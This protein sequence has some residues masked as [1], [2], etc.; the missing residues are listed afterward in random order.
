MDFD[1][2]QNYQSF[3]PPPASDFMESDLGVP[4]AEAT[5]PLRATRWVVF[6]GDVL[7]PA[8]KRRFAGMEMGGENLGQD[9]KCL[10]PSKGLLRRCQLTPMVVGYDFLNEDILGDDKSRAVSFQHFDPATN[11]T[12]VRYAYECLP[13]HEIEGLLRSQ[14]GGD[15]MG[16]REVEVLQNIDP[17]KPIKDGQGRTV[18]YSESLAHSIQREIFP[19]WDAYLLGENATGGKAFFRTS[20]KLGDYLRAR[21]AELFGDALDVIDVLIESNE[22]FI[23]WG[24]AYLSRMSRLVKAAPTPGGDTYSWSPLALQLFDML[25]LNKEEF[26]MRKIE[27]VK[28]EPE[29]SREEFSEMRQ[30]W[31]EVMPVIGHLARIAVANSA[32]TATGTAEPDY[33]AQV[34][35][36]FNGQ[37]NPCKARV[38]KEIDGA[39]YCSSHPRVEADADN[40]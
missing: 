2:Q 37:G 23:R 13:G 12:S 20:V 7:D 26:L 36:D 8:F 16:I 29:V 18:G 19:D 5:V 24:T 30:M 38:V 9:Y 40:Q 15:D 10:A 11:R 31:K 14:Q 21:R 27:D 1:I 17:P 25:E 33:T 28:S 35:A 4:T 6:A 3:T 22:Q 39:F 34:C 32:A